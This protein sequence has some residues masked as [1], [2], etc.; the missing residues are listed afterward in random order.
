MDIAPPQVGFT[1]RPASATDDTK[2]KEI[3]YQMQLN[4]LGLNW[5]RFILA[6]DPTGQIIGCGQ[7]KPHRD[8]LLE[9]ASLGVLPEWRGKGVARRIIE[10][11]LEK[12]PGRLYLTCR[13]ELEPLYQKFGFRTLNYTEMPRHYQ[14]ITR[15]VASFNWLTRRSDHLCVMR[16]N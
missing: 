8:G 4:P 11:L 5:R 7:V 1:L 12:Y 9:L 2:I 6:I 15:L 10:Y 16:R 14:R 13:S 3:I